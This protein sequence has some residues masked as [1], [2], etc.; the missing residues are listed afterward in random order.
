MNH[1][2]SASAV[3]HPVSPP[4]PPTDAPE[5]VNAPLHHPGLG[6]AG[7]IHSCRFEQLPGEF[8]ACSLPPGT[9]LPEWLGGAF[10][11]FCHGA[12][13]TTILCATERVPD[14]VTGNRDWQ[15]LHVTESAGLSPG[16]LI[17]AFIFPLKARHIDVITAAGSHGI[18]FLVRRHAL[19]TALMALQEAGHKLVAR[20]VIESFPVAFLAT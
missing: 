16:Q 9:A 3:T 2:P 12:A 13:E 14:H 18:C 6:Q 15:L 5:P 1:N 11:S 7:P 20:T 10:L 8:T 19:P 17:A 4:A